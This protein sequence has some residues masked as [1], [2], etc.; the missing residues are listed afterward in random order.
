MI[1]AIDDVSAY[2]VA[3]NDETTTFMA[4]TS[5]AA[6]AAGTFVYGTQT[7]A[8]IASEDTIDAVAAITGSPA[9]ATARVWAIVVDVNEAT[10]GAAE[11]DRDT[12]A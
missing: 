5:I 8:V 9:A 7:H 1:D 12:L 2:T 6:A 10:R 11:V 3:I 4:A